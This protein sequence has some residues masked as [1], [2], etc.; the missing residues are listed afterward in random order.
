MSR[1]H[2]L[3]PALLTTLVLTASSGMGSASAAPAPGRGDEAAA[4]QL[5]VIQ[6]NTDHVPQAWDFVVAQV[7]E[8]E[9]ELV[10]VQEVCRPWF[11]ALREAHPNWTFAYHPRKRH[12]GNSRNPGC[13]GDYIGELVIHTKAAN[14]PTMT[15]DYPN[16]NADGIEKFGMACVEF[17]HK[18]VPTLG[19]STHL[20]A[21]PTSGGR[22]TQPERGP[23]AQAIMGHTA[24]YRA[25]GWAVVLGGDLNMT[26]AADNPNQTPHM[27]I[28]LGT[29]VGG[30][31]DFYDA[32]QHECGC[33]L[34]EPTTDKGR[35][36][37][38]VLWSSG[39]TPF[40]GSATMERR[41]SP[42]GHHLLRSVGTL[43]RT[44]D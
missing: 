13:Q 18:G 14:R 26:S 8:F 33:R 32:A 42:A 19:C 21:Y 28:L 24:P 12:F 3:T 15:P 6:H 41:D 27:N 17:R 40:H 4:A 1:R 30:G 39:R 25:A 38:Y 10:A 23:Q 5:R 9:P 37:D 31:G 43:S 29:E 34:T 35:R 16:N 7:E 44:A 2:L 20:S 22:G 11:E 36:I